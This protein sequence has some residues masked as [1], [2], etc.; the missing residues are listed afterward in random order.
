MA[1]S[2][3]ACLTNQPQVLRNNSICR[4]ILSS[5]LQKKTTRNGQEAR[6]MWLP[7]T[8]WLGAFPS[9]PAQSGDHSS[10]SH[11]LQWSQL[12]HPMQVSRELTITTLHFLGW[13]HRVV[14]G[15]ICT[16]NKN[17]KPCSFLYPPR[18]NLVGII[19]HTV[20]KD[21]QV[22]PSLCIIDW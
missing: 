5:L 8:F 3:T 10:L 17:Y 6:Q 21:T 15:L 18:T 11:R 7:P 4:W 2:S 20:T 16:W 14:Q 12:Q 13:L 1:G 9:V 22:S 19:L